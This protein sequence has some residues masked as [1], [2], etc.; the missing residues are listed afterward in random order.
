[1]NNELITTELKDKVLEILVSE[2]E[3]E[4]AYTNIEVK[5]FL[6]RVPQLNY[7]NINAIFHRFNDDGLI[8][9]YN[10][11]ANGHTKISLLNVSELAHQKWT[12]GGY[13]LEE[14]IALQELDKLN[15]ELKR[16]KKKFN[17]DD[18]SNLTAIVTNITT[19]FNTIFRR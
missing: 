3:P 2:L 10:G 17:L 5:E 8:K 13:K 14:L 4:T 7:V 6:E 18:L 16:L 1:M 11:L 12:R 19:S 15:E 9:G